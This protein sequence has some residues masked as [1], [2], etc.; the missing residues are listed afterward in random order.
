MSGEL[1]EIPAPPE[2]YCFLNDTRICNPSCV[3]YLVH[4]PRGDEYRIEEPWMH[5]SVLLNGHRT[6]KHLV[7]L[8][9]TAEKTVKAPPPALPPP[10]ATR[11]PHGL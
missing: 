3:A 1:P 11:G 10:P 5:C 7:V 4:L 6:G 9:Q 8:A 2:V